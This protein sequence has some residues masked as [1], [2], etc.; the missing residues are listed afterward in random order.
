MGSGWKANIEKHGNRFAD[1]E[2]GRKAEGGRERKPLGP[3]GGHKNDV[4]AFLCPFF[5]EDER[6]LVPSCFQVV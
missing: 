3:V 4:S 1:M 2:S 6:P 5:N